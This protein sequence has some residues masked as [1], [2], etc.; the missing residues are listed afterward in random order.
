MPEPYVPG[1]ENISAP[2]ASNPYLWGGTGKDSKTIR[3]GMRLID[4]YRAKAEE[5]YQ[6][7]MAKLANLEQMYENRIAESDKIIANYSKFPQ[8]A[9]GLNHYKDYTLGDYK[10]KL[11]Q[12]KKGLKQWLESYDD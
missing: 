4:R 8:V 5:L 11:D 12:N 6:T 10:Q 9:T 3:K 1:M 2:N 7:E